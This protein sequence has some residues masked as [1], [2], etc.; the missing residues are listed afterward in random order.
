M[1]YKRQELNKR[2]HI[3]IDYLAMIVRAVLKIGTGV[4]C[5]IAGE[6]FLILW[7]VVMIVWKLNNL[8]E[9]S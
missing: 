3:S 5:F 6:K 9:Q 8:K 7:A 4:I 1:S 2:D